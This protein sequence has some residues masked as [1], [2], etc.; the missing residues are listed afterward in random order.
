ME[1]DVTLHLPAEHFKSL[2]EVFAIGLSRA[3]LK[4]EIRQELRA[5]WEA[6]KEFVKDEIANPKK[7]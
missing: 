6:E 2:S 1:A 3:K 4:P 5:W 7:H